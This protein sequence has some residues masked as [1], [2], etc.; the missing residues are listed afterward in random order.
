MTVLHGRSVPRLEGKPAYRFAAAG[1][2]VR[3]ELEDGG[4]ARGALPRGDLGERIRD[5][6]Q[7]PDGPVYVLTDES[8]GRVLQVLPSPGRES[9]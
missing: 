7:G 1:A 9:P 8:D 2:L 5:V 6:Q 3:L 4:G